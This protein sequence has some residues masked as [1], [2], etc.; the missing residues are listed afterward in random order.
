MPSTRALARQLG[1][2]RVTVLAAYDEL[3]ARG[4]LIGRHGSGT[5]VA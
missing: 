2:S 1:L 4:I 3:V 5:Y